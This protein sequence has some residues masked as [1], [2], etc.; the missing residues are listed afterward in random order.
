VPDDVVVRHP[1][2]DPED[3]PVAEPPRSETTRPAGKPSVWGTIL[4]LAGMWVAGLL[5]LG[6]GQLV[7]EYLLDTEIRLG[8]LPVLALGFASVALVRKR[9]GKEDR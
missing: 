4:R 5:V 2:R 6:G 1:A 8:F 7:A 3:I 9:H